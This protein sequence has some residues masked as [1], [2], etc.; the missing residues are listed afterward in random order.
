MKM[1]I[2][3]GQNLAGAIIF[4]ICIIVIG[5]AVSSFA[6][7]ITAIKEVKNDKKTYAETS[8]IINQ[9]RKV[10]GYHDSRYQDDTQIKELRKSIS[11]IEKKI[12]KIKVEKYQD[13]VEYNQITEKNILDFMNGKIYKLELS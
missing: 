8:D 9:Y 1:Y 3:I 2:E 4:S 6:T 11:D 12:E 5:W 13:D 7:T 10:R